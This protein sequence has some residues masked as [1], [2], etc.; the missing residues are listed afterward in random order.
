MYSDKK[1][2]GSCL[3]LKRRSLWK[4]SVMI[5][6][7]VLQVYTSVKTYQIEP[8]KQMWFSVYVNFISLKLIKYSPSDSCNIQV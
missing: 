5:K 7:I 1:E 4:C 3:V 8:F 2:I 6:L